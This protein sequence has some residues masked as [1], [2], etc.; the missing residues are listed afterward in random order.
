MT[1]TAAIAW[2]FIADTVGKFACEK[3]ILLLHNGVSVPGVVQCLP[4]PQF[5]GRKVNRPLATWKSIADGKVSYRINVD[6]CVLRKWMWTKP[7]LRI[8][9][10]RLWRA[11]TEELY[12][13]MNFQLSGVQIT[14]TFWLM[15][16]KKIELILARRHKRIKLN[17][18]GMTCTLKIASQQREWKGLLSQGEGRRKGIDRYTLPQSSGHPAHSNSGAVKA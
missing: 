11:D 14:C 7:S 18:W 1:R 15:A 10:Q 6:I 17:I 12:V 3:K 16:P 8:W 9:G 2:F 5:M 13:I 4:P